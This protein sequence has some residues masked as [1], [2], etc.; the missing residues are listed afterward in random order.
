M[1]ECGFGPTLIEFMDLV[2]EF[3]TLKGYQTPFK[4]NRPGYDWT[5]SFLKRQKLS[6]KKGGQMQLARKNVTS[7]PFVVYEFYETLS[8]EVE[9]LGIAN[10][11]ESFYNCDE[12]G[13]PVDPSKCKYI[14]RVGK[15]TIQVTHGAIRENQTVLAVCSADGKA[16]D[17]LIV[18]KGKSLQSTWLGSESLKD[19]YFAASENGWMT[20]KIFHDWFTKFVKQVETR[21]LLLLFDGH[22][23]HLSL[24]TIDLAIE[25][26]ISLVKLPAHCTDILQPLD[27][28]CFSP[29]K[30]SYEKLLTEFVHRTGGRQKLSKP[31]FCNLI[32]TI[33]REGLTKE[34]IVSGFE[35]TGILPVDHTKYKVDRLDK[36]KLDSY[37]KWKDS[38]SPKDSD[39]NPIVESL[40]T[41]LS[42]T[43]DST[44]KN[45][46]QLH[47]AISSAIPTT[48]SPGARKN[49]SKNVLPFSV[50][51]FASSLD[52]S[53]A[54]ESDVPCCSSANNSTP[55]STTILT[56]EQILEILAKNAP[57]GYK[58]CLTLV[59]RET[60]S[61]EKVLKNRMVT[62]KVNTSTNNSNSEQPTRHNISMHGA[63]VSNAEFREKIVKA[64]EEKAKKQKKK[65]PK[66]KIEFQ[67]KEKGAVKASSNKKA[68]TAV[69]ENGK[70][71]RKNIKNFIA[72]AEG[73]VDD[74]NKSDEGNNDFQPVHEHD[75]QE[76][77]FSSEPSNHQVAEEKSCD[78]T[79][80]VSKTE[81]KQLQDLPVIE[82]EHIGK[83]YAVFWPKPKA[84]YWGKLMKV[85]SHDV[86]DD[87]NEV[88]I[89]FLKKVVNSSDPSLIKWDWP[90]VEDKGVVDAK[91]LFAGPMI[92]E[93]S[94]A[95]RTKSYIQFK[96]EPEILKKYNDIVKHGLHGH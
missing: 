71:F 57:P 5:H 8:K 61:M 80:V 56:Q 47:S 65:K 69:T 37:K 22:L 74:E 30:Q 86:E 77:C 87:A 81:T 7:D 41:E 46:P 23:T 35:K 12:S 82:E 85:F 10:K 9:R 18:F 62:K 31:A 40:A 33:W 70:E 63:V 45:V 67:E 19:T 54:T 2:Q 66:R 3:V 60:D 14:G 83:F 50:E 52:N 4:E 43:I 91:L 16:L 24:A 53:V 28:S 20:T 48:Q 88:E 59:P 78:E 32:A 49:A 95:S 6:L 13:F 72:S 21:P 51:S 26:N 34:N 79:T 27:V 42:A 84:Y 76:V 38:G 17:P 92:P 58:Y 68:K 15:K 55:L 90:S 36:V 75:N 25:E 89:N 44:G 94:D 1:S 96:A 64:K 39:G 29:L 11:P 93:V 73:K